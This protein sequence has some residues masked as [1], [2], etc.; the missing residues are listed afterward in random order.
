MK[1][2]HGSSNCIPDKIKISVSSDL[3]KIVISRS[4]NNRKLVD[5]LNFTY[6]RQ[7]VIF[8]THISGNE[9]KCESNNYIFSYGVMTLNLRLRGTK[10]YS[11]FIPN[12]YQF[13]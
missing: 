4:V 3:C 13:L 9:D 8:M 5:L 1:D 10:M 7:L 12:M 11:K 2:G 6:Q